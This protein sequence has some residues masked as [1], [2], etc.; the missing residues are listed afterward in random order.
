MSSVIEKKIQ[1]FF[2]KNKCVGLSLTIRCG[3]F[4]WISLAPTI[5]RNENSFQTENMLKAHGMKL[6][7]CTQEKITD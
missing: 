3:L 5:L 6:R 4:D 1:F 2:Q 7:F